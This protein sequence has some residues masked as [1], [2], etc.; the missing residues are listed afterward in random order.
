MFTMRDVYPHYAILET[1]ERT[2][3]VEQ[4]RKDPFAKEDVGFATPQE[5][6]NIW[7]ALIGFVVLLAIFAYGGSIAIGA[8]ASVGK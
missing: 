2:I 1:T 5:R 8:K 6:R 7:L 4:H 3:P